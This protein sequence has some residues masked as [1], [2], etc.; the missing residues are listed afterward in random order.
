MFFCSLLKNR[1]LCNLE[2]LCIWMKTNTPLELLFL[3]HEKH[4]QFPQAMKITDREYLY[5]LARARSLRQDWKGVRLFWAA[6]V[7]VCMKFLLRAQSY[8]YVWDRQISLFLKNK[9]K[10]KTGVNSLI[11]V[12][13]L[14]LP[15]HTTSLSALTSPPPLTPRCKTSRPPRCSSAGPSRGPA[16]RLARSCGSLLKPARRS[17]CS[18]ALSLALSCSF[19]LCTYTFLHLCSNSLSISASL[20]VLIFAYI[21]PTCIS[22]KNNTFLFLS[23]SSLPCQVLT[24][25]TK[26]ITDANERFQTANDVGL[27]EEAVAVSYILSGCGL[28]VCSFWS[29]FLF[30]NSVFILSRYFVLAR[31][32]LTDL[33]NCAGIDWAAWSWASEAI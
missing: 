23:P 20:F 18:L 9:I 19:C 11:T 1:L 13:I 4:T 33:F 7:R 2:L 29:Y 16:S 15:N 30:A 28:W 6:C 26:L 32:E 25:F 14:S 17:R 22:H 27:F 10:I 21:A 24:S 12:A 31:I 5:G 3:S 8:I